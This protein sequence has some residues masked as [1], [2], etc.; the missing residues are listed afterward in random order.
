MI[1]VGILLSFKYY[2]NAQLDEIILQYEEPVNADFAT[3]EERGS[4]RLITRYSSVSYFLHHGLER[5]FEYEFL[6][7]FANEYGLRVEVVIPAEGED[8]IDV[9]NRGDGDVIAQNYSITP[10]RARFIEFSEPY[11]LVDQIL[12]LPSHME[13]FYP[14]V[15]SLKGL[16]V[17]VRRGSSYYYTLRELQKRGVDVNI[18]IVPEHLEY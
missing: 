17:S 9:L 12:V 8:P 10:K 6:K 14:A 7:E 1:I 15:D 4:I 18:D 2:N 13:G 16:T 11:N 3:I 5:G